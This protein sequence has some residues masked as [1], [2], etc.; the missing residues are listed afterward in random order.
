MFIAISYQQNALNTNTKKISNLLITTVTRNDLIY[1]VS[2]ENEIEDY[3]TNIE[4]NKYIMFSLIVLLLIGPLMM[5]IWF[6][7]FIRN[8]CKKSKR[9]HHKKRLYDTSQS[10]DSNASWKSS[11]LSTINTDQSNDCNCMIRI[12]KHKRKRHNKSYHQFN[13]S[14]K[15]ILKKAKSFENLL[16]ILRTKSSD[17]TSNSSYDNLKSK[18]LYFSAN[19]LNLINVKQFLNSSSFKQH[20]KDSNYKASIN[21]LTNSTIE[22]FDDYNE[23]YSGSIRNTDLN[24][25]DKILVHKTH[26]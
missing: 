19:H 4:A 18:V 9:K 21:T 26:I 15:N 2:S 13:K 20:K 1:R 16:K 3:T 14:S 10:T 12:N 24:L 5:T 22:N 25:F 6:I 8:L 23:N 7:K 17:K 11:S